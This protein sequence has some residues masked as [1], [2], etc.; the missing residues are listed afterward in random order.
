MQIDPGTITI[1]RAM[2][3]EYKKTGPNNQRSDSTP[4]RVVDDDDFFGKVTGYSSSS[5]SG[6]P[7]RAVYVVA[8]Q[9]R[10]PTGWQDHPNG[11]SVVALNSIEAFNGST[12][13]GTMG[14]SI[15]HSS[16]SG[17]PSSDW[18]LTVRGN[19]VVRIFGEYD[20]TGKKVYSFQYV[21]G[22]QGV[23]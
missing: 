15:N 11:R 14:N 9:Q 19:P 5:I 1:L 13:S 12:N 23:C 6:N 8:Q 17:Y 4:K 22:E 21:N 3:H 18:F 10:T 2:V 20:S 7:H 16:G